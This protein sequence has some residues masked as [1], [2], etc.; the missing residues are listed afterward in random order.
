MEDDEDLVAV[1]VVGRY[2]EAAHGRHQLSFP[3][4]GR[5]CTGGCVAT[6]SQHQQPL[7]AH[8]LEPAAGRSPADALEVGR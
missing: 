8:P 4:L 5:P 3:G 6:D 2:L 1:P 7:P